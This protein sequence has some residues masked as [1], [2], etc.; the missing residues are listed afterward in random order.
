MMEVDGR[1]GK[2]KLNPVERHVFATRV[3]RAREE[4]LGVLRATCL[5]EMV[6]LLHQVCVGLLCL[7]VWVYTHA[8]VC[9]S[10]CVGGKEVYIIYKYIHMYV[11]VCGKG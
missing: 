10:A 8:Y 7:W 4:E 6:A 11:C 5:P 3:L 9:G 2:P 1:R